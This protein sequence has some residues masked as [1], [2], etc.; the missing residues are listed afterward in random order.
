MPGAA[1]RKRLLLRVLCVCLS[2][3][4]DREGFVGDSALE[5]EDNVVGPS[6]HLELVAEGEG[7]SS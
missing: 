5:E 7:V 2:A 4:L 1:P 3:R 6:S